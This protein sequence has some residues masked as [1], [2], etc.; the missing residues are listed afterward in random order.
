MSCQG[1]AAAAFP[2]ES[3]E[4]G[5]SCR[6]RCSA[7][8]HPEPPA[9][10]AAEQALGTVLWRERQERVCSKIR[11]SPPHRQDGHGENKHENNGLLSGAEHEQSPRRHLMI[12]R[13]LPCI[14]CSPPS[15]AG[16]VPTGEGA[17]LA[18]SADDFRV[19]FDK[20]AAGLGKG[21]AESHSPPGRDRRRLTSDPKWFGAGR[22]AHPS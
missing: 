15:Q 10:R 4:G 7:P 1:G 12:C 6:N 22:N 14:S 13:A 5:Q 19:S 9:P 17:A 20:G 8:G 18:P 16:Q 11:G 21:P 2:G 3:G